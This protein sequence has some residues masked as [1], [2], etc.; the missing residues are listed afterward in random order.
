MWCDG[1]ERASSETIGAIT[2]PGTQSTG[3]SAPDDGS[4]CV[5]AATPSAQDR[6]RDESA[7]EA[8]NE[9]CACPPLV[10]PRNS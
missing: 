5:Q 2:F 8:Q 10:P 6:A 3:V 7:E 9:E 1:S 4:E